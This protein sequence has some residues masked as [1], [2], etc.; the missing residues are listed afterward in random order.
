MS[1]E[2]YAAECATRW[3]E[4]L[5][6]WGQKLDRIQ[7][8]RDT[9]EF[10]IYTPGSDAGLPMAVLKSF[11][12]PPASLRDSADAMR[13]RVAAAASGLLVLLGID[14]DPIRSREHILISNILDHAWRE[15]RNLTIAEL[16]HEIQLPPF[17][18]LG[19]MDL[20]T[21]IPEKDRL[22]LAMT[23]N[24]VLAS[25][26]FSAWMEGE[27]LNIQRLL[28]TEGGKPRVSVISIAHLSDA[29]RMFFL[30]ILLNEVLTWMR[31]QSGT[32]SLRALLYMD[33]VFGYLPPVANPPTK[34][35]LLSML[36]Q[37]RAFGLG[38]V[39]A[40]QNPVDLDYKALSNTGT[41][42]LGRLQT[43]R[44]KQRVLDGLEGASVS[45]GAKFDRRRIEQVLS[46]LSSR[47]FLMNNVHEDEPVV[48]HTRWSLSFLRG[49]LTREQIGRLMHPMKEAIAHMS[50]TT[51][52][53]SP[54]PGKVRPVSRDAD[55]G[56]L[57]PLPPVVPGGIVQQYVAIASE[58][59][60]AD[61]VVYRPSVVGTGRIHFSDRK[62]GADKLVDIVRVCDVSDGVP[63]RL[64]SDAEVWDAGFVE[65]EDRPQAEARFAVLDSD[66]T[67]PKN[68]STW[69]SR[70]KDHLYGS[71]QL[72]LLY[73]DS[74]DVYSEPGEAEGDFRVRLKHQA[75]ELR[76]T[77]VQNL[78][79]RYAPKFEKLQERIRK[80]EQRVDVQR[81]QAE[82]ATTSAA[83]SAG[84]T[85]FGWLF[86]RKL[87]S[88]AT[89]T[90]AGSAM[91]SA[92]R[93]S[94]QKSDVVRAEEDVD[95]LQEEKEA[96]QRELEQEIDAITQGLSVDQLIL[97][98]YVVKPYKKD[99]SI[100][101]CGLLWLPGCRN[102]DGDEESAW[103]RP[104]V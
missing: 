26:S 35:P 1:P 61:Q 56:D 53:D 5:D 64:W 6:V 77:E 18:R 96:L 62:S 95:K 58:R 83:V 89:A 10:T 29:E 43:E 27:P 73:C 78:R 34:L 90:S 41:W 66:L 36:K 22:A 32:S 4:G 85:V 67:Q 81:E 42:F 94:Q 104:D 46:S 16:I 33:E 70:L 8:L 37:A 47:V 63:R 49:P 20:D 30:T 40:T 82:A 25:P 24:N 100:D 57:S 28:Y 21:V 68:F 84:Q 39:L 75:H 31:S 55:D 101:T 65:F 45:A 19:V 54:R 60:P 17:E 51:D 103:L 72:T 99:I 2:E 48:F 93:A 76:D 87:R 15:G 102:E 52:V 11:D 9:A 79:T 13:E 80:A 98:S 69:K 74:L 44:D 38:L 23:V 7:N 71:E 91:R 12:A 50:P 88:T 14:P 3:R 86:G 92:S 97:D 59:S